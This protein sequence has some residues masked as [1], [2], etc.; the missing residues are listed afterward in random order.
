MNA[1]RYKCGMPV[2][3]EGETGVGKTA[4]IEMLSK[5]WNHALLLRLKRQRGR[6]LDVM[7]KK[8]GDISA[9]DS[10]NYEVNI[11]QLFHSSLLFYLLPQFHPLFLPKSF[12][13]T[14]VQL[15]EALS[16]GEDVTEEDLI[17]LGQLPDPKYGQGQGQFYCQLRSKLLSMKSDPLVTL[18]ILPESQPQKASLEQLFER[19]E[20]ENSAEVCGSMWWHKKPKV[21]FLARYWQFRVLP[22]LFCF[23]HTNT[24]Q[25][26]ASLLYGV[27]LAKIM[28]TFH[29]LNIHSAMT[30]TD[31]WSY[32]EPVF[33]Q[34]KELQEAFN[35]ADRS[36]APFVTVSTW[37]LVSIVDH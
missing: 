35:M 31:L 16:A 25:S 23:Q 24:H 19:A 29:K 18:L 37:A 10:D 9:E 3:I 30:A 1:H 2:I 17:L 32:L 34:A 22:E 7:R 8:L 21:V 6:L 33:S 20:T 13:Q 36:T 4:L 15:V 12:P 5:L 26:T 27:M 11:F 14:C 28:P